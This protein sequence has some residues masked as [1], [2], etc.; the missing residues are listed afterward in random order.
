VTDM[1]SSLST[2]LEDY[3]LYKRF[4]MEIQDGT[5]LIGVLP[6]AIS[7]QCRVCD[8]RQTYVSQGRRWADDNHNPFRNAEGWW[9][10]AICT[11]LCALCKKSRTT[12]ILQV[13]D[14]KKAI[15]KVGQ[16]PA[17]SID[18]DEVVTNALG[19]HISDFKKGLINESH[20]YGIGAY[21]YYRRI[22][23]TIID[24]LLIDISDS[25]PDGAEHNAFREAFERVRDDK[26]ADRRIEA[27]KDLVPAILRPGGINPLSTLHS[28]LS[29]GLHGKSDEECLDDAMAV[30]NS[31]IFLIEQVTRT[32][33]QAKA[34][35][36]S[37]KALLEK[38][39]KRGSEKAK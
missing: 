15:M 30:R 28:T 10:C 34:Y 26:R 12:F 38:Q 33:E 24:A 2:L 17:W 36:A 29:E 7:M 25:I 8:S 39:A 6:E 13:T 14:D 19:S 27:V 4:V 16:Y 11:F 22:V 35:E 31:L 32:K 9:S 3:P 37:M 18:V 5:H 20:S 1:S 23:E 21:A